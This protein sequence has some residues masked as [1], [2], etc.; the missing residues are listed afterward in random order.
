VM[1]TG[2]SRPAGFSRCLQ[3][4]SRAHGK[5]HV[6]VL[7]VFAERMSVFAAR[8]GVAL[9]LNATVC[10]RTIARYFFTPIMFLNQ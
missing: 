7:W 8:C 6:L 9:Q 4:V 3:A 1:A 5:P 2:S 10:V